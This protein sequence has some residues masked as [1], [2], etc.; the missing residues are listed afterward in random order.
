MREFRRR[1]TGPKQGVYPAGGNDRLVK[2]LRPTLGK[3]P[4]A[5]ARSCRLRGPKVLLGVC[6]ARRTHRAALRRR[7]AIAAHFERTDWDASGNPAAIQIGGGRATRLVLSAVAGFSLACDL[8]SFLHLC[9]FFAYSFATHAHRIASIRVP[10]LRL[11]EKCKIRG[12]HVGITEWLLVWLIA[13]ALFVVWRVLAVFQA[14]ARP[15]SVRRQ[16]AG[17]PLDQQAVRGRI[18]A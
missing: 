8:P 4:R 14:E 7:S 15:L 12:R 10:D 11:L 18:G 2:A 16:V 13:N 9:R 17:Q 6:R 5:V 1:M 3:I